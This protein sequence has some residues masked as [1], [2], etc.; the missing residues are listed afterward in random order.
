MGFRERLVRRVSWTPGAEG[1]EGFRVVWVGW[2]EAGTILRDWSWVLVVHVSVFGW[3][4]ADE[5]H[6]P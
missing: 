6:V 1:A 5:L 4:G 3:E 2:L